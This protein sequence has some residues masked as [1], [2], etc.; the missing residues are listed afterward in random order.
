MKVVDQSHKELVK[1]MPRCP[2]CNSYMD[3]YGQS[4]ASSVIIEGITYYCNNPVCYCVNS[5][6]EDHD[7]KT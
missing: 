5:P 1:E 6:S 7:A 2:C 4:F 3:T